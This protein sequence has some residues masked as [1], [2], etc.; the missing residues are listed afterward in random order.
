MRGLY[1][2]GRFVRD[3]T[4]IALLLGAALGLLCWLGPW[5]TGAGFTHA[6]VYGGLAALLVGGLGCGTF[7]SAGSRPDI[8][9][10]GSMPLLPFR[11]GDQARMIARDH[12]AAP[13]VVPFPLRLLVAGVLVL[14]VGMVASSM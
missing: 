5:R 3:V 10:R 9:S 14:A 13:R 8:F 6:L 2:T 1:A 4:L 11:S 12:A 7:F